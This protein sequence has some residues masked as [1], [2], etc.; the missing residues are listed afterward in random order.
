MDSSA[1]G[2]FKPPGASRTTSTL[3]RDPDSARVLKP[4][5][6][7]GAP[8]HFTPVL[9]ASSPETERPHKRFRLLYEKRI[10]LFAILAASPGVAFGT[11]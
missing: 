11:V 5:S 6:E 7:S 8:A 10:A 4:N 3:A 1:G 2:E 9:G